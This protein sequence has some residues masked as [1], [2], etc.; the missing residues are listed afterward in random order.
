[1]G[2]GHLQCILWCILWPASRGLSWEPVA[3]QNTP[4][5]RYGMAFCHNADSIFIYGG[6]TVK[7][8]MWSNGPMW[9]NDVNDILFVRPESDLL[10]L[11]FTS[12][13]WRHILST[14]VGSLFSSMVCTDDHLYLFGGFRG[15]VYTSALFQ[16]NVTTD[17]TFTLIQ[18]TNPPS[19]RSLHSMVNFKGT[20]YI[21]GGCNAQGWLTDIWYL[22]PGNNWRWLTDVPFSSTTPPQLQM[23][24]GY[25]IGG[26]TNLYILGH[27]LSSCATYFY[28]AVIDN[29]GLVQLYS[30]PLP[31]LC[32]NEG[33]LVA[34]SGAVFFIGNNYVNFFNFEGPTGSSRW[35]SINATAVPNLTN[36]NYVGF[37]VGVFANSL[38]TFGGFVAAQNRSN[39][40]LYTGNMLKLNLSKLCNMIWAWRS[41]NLRYCGGFCCPLDNVCMFE[42]LADGMGN[43]LMCRAECCPA[44][45]CTAN[46]S[47]PYFCNGKCV[48]PGSCH[49]SPSASVATYAPN[50]YVA[51]HGRTTAGATAGIGV[52]SAFIACVFFAVLGY[53]KVKNPS[54]SVDTT[55]IPVTRQRVETIEIQ[56][57]VV[58]CPLDGSYQLQTVSTSHH[59][60]EY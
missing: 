45:I 2:P 3:A 52:G 55:V 28:Q 27:T 51:P 10:Q 60:S 44:H 32:S 11:D 5:P 23:V 42:D 53:C 21:S 36:S 34:Y 46:L 35:R 7:P 9:C 37:S 31:S 22:A 4:T 14:D 38:F 40:L 58:H 6:S 17:P 39:A 41:D 20:I 16:I 49:P 12:L 1:M 43:E 13:T 8:R 48:S 54:R 26:N 59:V 19:E 30:L 50:E 29:L 15:G 57:E 18:T 56:Q 33:A 25:S 47:N 24:I